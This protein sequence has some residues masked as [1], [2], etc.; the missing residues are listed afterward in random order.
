MRKV[1]FRTV[2]C[3]HHAAKVSV[4]EHVFSLEDGD[5]IGHSAEAAER[6]GAMGHRGYTNPG[7]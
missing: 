3:W 7:C 5:P 1:L 2:S 4:H 6:E